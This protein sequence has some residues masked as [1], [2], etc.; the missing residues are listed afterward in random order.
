MTSP[1]TVTTCRVCAGPTQI[2][3]RKG[4][5]PYTCTTPCTLCTHPGDVHRDWYRDQNGA[6]FCRRCPEGHRHDFTTQEPPR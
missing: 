1:P 2:D 4:C 5:T 6:G 3:A